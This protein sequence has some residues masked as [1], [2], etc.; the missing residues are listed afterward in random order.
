MSSM[1]PKIAELK[2]TWIGSP[3]Y[4]FSFRFSGDM[5]LAPEISLT[6]YAICVLSNLSM[7]VSKISEFYCGMLSAR[8][9]PDV[10]RVTLVHPCSAAHEPHSVGNNPSR[11]LRHLIRLKSAIVLTKTKVPMN[12]TKQT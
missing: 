5:T 1:K 11:S 9:H 3:C 6:H 2:V 10:S 12:T 8:V 4:S 7:F